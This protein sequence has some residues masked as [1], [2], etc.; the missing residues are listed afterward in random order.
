MNQRRD[1]TYMGRSDPD[2]T[3]EY[4]FGRIQWLRQSG[5]GDRENL[6]AGIW[7]VTPDELPAR[8]PHEV[9]ADKT[10]YIIAGSTRIEIEDGPTYELSEGSM[11]SFN[12]GTRTVETVLRPLTEFF[13]YSG[14]SEE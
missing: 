4:I 10:I 9:P 2:H 1:T 14:K 8:T 13:V 12:R 7:R 6:S 11:A 5:D 3:E